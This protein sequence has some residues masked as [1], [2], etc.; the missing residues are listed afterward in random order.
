MHSKISYRLLDSSDMEE[1]MA[2]HKEWFP[3][4]YPP[5]YFR[6][7]KKNNVIAIGCFYDIEEIS[8]TLSGSDDGG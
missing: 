7:I 1:I 4:D 2:L 6:K 5:D 8:K 3:L